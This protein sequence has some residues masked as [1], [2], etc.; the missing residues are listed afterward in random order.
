M[1]LF[2]W[3]QVRAIVFP[4]CDLTRVKKMCFLFLTIVHFIYVDM[5]VW[6]TDGKLHSREKIQCVCVCVCNAK[7]F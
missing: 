7:Y 1:K 2:M 3:I 4:L 5:C 6:F